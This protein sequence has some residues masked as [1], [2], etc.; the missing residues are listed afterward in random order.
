MQ[1]QAFLAFW[2]WKSLPWNEAPPSQELF[3][4]ERTERLAQRLLFALSRAG[5]V[6]VIAAPAGHGKSTFAK[7][8][9]G[10]LNPKEHD[11]ALFSLMRKSPAGDWLMQ[12]LADY[13]GLSSR[14]PKDIIHHLHRS[15]LQGRLLTLIIDEAH[16]LVDADAFEALFALG[17]VSSR[18]GFGLNCVLIGRPE[19]LKTLRGISGVQHR[20]G[21]CTELQALSPSELAAFVN[22]KLNA[23]Q[24][25]PKT[26][27]SEALDLLMQ[28]EIGTFAAVESVLEA[29]LL[30]AFL[31]EQR[32]ISAEAMSQA[33]KFLG[34]LKSDETAE[35]AK[36]RQALR[37]RPQVPS[38]QRAAAAALDL[39]SLYY[40]SDD[41]QDPE[42]S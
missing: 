15:Q 1:S 33:L 24:L 2:G 30:E 6:S 18:I 10:S 16:K 19:L 20:L 31:Q 21:L 13:L 28:H 42:Q 7:W 29:C 12:A 37:R 17:Q 11:V 4:Q 22:Y 41:G 8:L 40:K 23:W 35:S 25:G 34:L 27:Q 38:Q 5:Q 14:E 26:L 39:N 32:S 9:Y 36:G 3:W